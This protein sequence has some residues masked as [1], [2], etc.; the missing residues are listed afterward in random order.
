M[1]AL[2]PL[3]VGDEIRVYYAAENRPHALTS[4]DA[5]LLNHA[6][7]AAPEA[8]AGQGWLRNGA[9]FGALARCRRDG[10]VSLDSGSSLGSLLTRPFT[11]RGD[12]IVINADAT[13][14][15]FWVEI[16]DPGAGHWRVS[17]RRTRSG[18]KEIPLVTWPSGKRAGT[19]RP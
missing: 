14:G 15:E 18:F 2:T 13:R 17:A 3:L 12:R 10:F 4:Q 8:P 5:T 1:R 9:G 19:S 11:F 16:L 7:E 6:V